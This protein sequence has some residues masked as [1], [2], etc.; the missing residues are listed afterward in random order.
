[1]KKN[2]MLF[3]VQI[4]FSL[5]IFKA[6]SQQGHWDSLITKN[7]V[8]GRSECGMAAS[9]GKLYLIGGDGASS[10]EVFDPAELTWSKKSAPPVGMNHFEAVSFNNNIYVLEAFESGGFPNQTNLSNVYIYNTRTDSWHTGSGL[11]P[12]RRRAAAGAVEYHGKLYLVNGIQHG[13]SSGTTNMFDVYDPET[14]RWSLLPD[15]PHIRDHCE[16]AVVGD[17]LYVAGGRN[18]SYRDPNNII[19]FFS[20]TVLD[21]DCYDF[22]S[23]TWSTLSA[24]LPLGSGGGSMVNLNGIL[25]YFGGERATQAERNAPRKNTFYLDP[26]NSTR[27][28]E[29]D[30]LKLARNGMSAAVLNNKIYAFGGTG[31]GGPMPNG[32][33]G[34]PP[35]GMAMNQ[36]NDSLRMRPPQGGGPERQ[37]AFSPLEVFTVNNLQ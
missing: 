24:K 26:V 35:P 17:K 3:V 27:W 29:S 23:G 10:V 1:M 32:P 7:Q 33:A 12:E 18:T 31:S 37:Q 34:G 13:H 9:N 2:L 4:C 16:A 19:T 6:Y 22:K 11:V 5:I 21:V 25:Y 20:Q 28:V 14:D 8:R 36:P 30:S 15:A